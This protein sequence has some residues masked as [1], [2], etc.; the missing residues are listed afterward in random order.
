MEENVLLNLFDCDAI[1]F[2]QFKLKSGQQS[3]IYIDLRVIVSYPSL[4][5]CD[6][7]YCS[8][9][10][11]TKGMLKNVMYDKIIINMYCTYT[12][13]KNL[14]IIKVYKSNYS[15]SACYISTSDQRMK[16]DTLLIVGNNDDACVDID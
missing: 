12:F 6:K 11:L 10:S 9:L 14:V 15:F 3:P 4:M 5:V 7:F 1:K 13:I 8:R 16:S 2:G